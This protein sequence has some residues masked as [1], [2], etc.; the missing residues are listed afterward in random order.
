MVGWSLDDQYVV[1]CSSDHLVRVWC[2]ITGKLLKLLR[3]HTD[4][5]Y[6]IEAHPS[7]PNLLL[8]A[9]HDGE[10]LISATVHIGYC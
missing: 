7:D 6:V 1:T 9:G 4:D 2:S 3:G 5:A 10:R 8:T